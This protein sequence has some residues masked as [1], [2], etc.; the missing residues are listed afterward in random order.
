MSITKASERVAVLAAL[1]PVSRSAGTVTSGWVPVSAWSSV[2]AVLQAG[3][4]GSSATVDAKLQQ[5]KDA[6]GTGAKDITGKA[7]SQW[8]QAGTDKSNKQAIVNVRTADLDVANDFTHVRFSVTTA[9]AASVSSALLLGIGY[10]RGAATAGNA[11]S[12][13]QVVG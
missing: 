8:T 9:T 2:L 13:D 5:A 4:L 1:D 3:A 12:V 6:S 7:I 10:R 11:A